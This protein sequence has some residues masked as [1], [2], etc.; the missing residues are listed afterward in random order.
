MS[1]IAANLSKYFGAQCAVDDLS[2]QVQTGEIVGFLGPNGAGKSTTMRMLTGYLPP[3]AGEVTIC[4][5]TLGQRQ[6]FQRCIG[7]LPEH[8][9]LYHEMYVKE[10]LQ[11]MGEARGLAQKKVKQRVVQLIDDC[12]ICSLPNEFNSTLDDCGICD[13]DNSTCSG[14]SDP[15]ALNFDDFANLLK[16]N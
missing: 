6:Q 7:Y 2:F 10:Y 14:C 13:G 16:F 1:I 15:N 12:G 5:Y 11:F 4:G 9:P 8:N 3:H